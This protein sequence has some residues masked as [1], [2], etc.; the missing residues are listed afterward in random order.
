MDDL[1]LLR[2]LGR[3]LEHEPPATLAAQ[4]NRLGRT[5]RSPRRLRGWMMISLAAAAT[6]LAVAVPT[7]FLTGHKTVAP[8]AGARPA[9][10]T[11]ALNILLV[12]SDSQA[13]SGQFPQGA[14]SDTL[15][16]VHIPEDRKKV[17]A[18]NLPRDLMVK[19]PACAKGQ[20]VMINAGFNAGGLACAVQTVESVTDL[21]MDHAMSMDFRGF[22][23]LVNALGGVEIHVPKAVN[24]RKAKLNLP[25]GTQVL[26]G[27]QALGWARLRSYGDG[28]DLSRIK[29]QQVLMKAMVKKAKASLTDPGKLRAFVQ[30]GQKWV[31]TTE[32]FDL[33]T[34]YAVASELGGSTP[35]FVTVPIEA[36][37]GDPNRL[38]L[39]QPEAGKLFDKLK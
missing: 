7:M 35:T 32:G 39:R 27:K 16:I 31:T 5:T 25:A 23:D 4:R 36:Y 22:E 30:A 34:M 33:E 26:N 13:G 1:K 10:V 14:R 21:R 29:R 2:D 12:G 9:K 17:T 6:A 24:D 11:G 8:P 37:P 20:T 3:E 15:I 19:G 38:Q 28:S 18:V